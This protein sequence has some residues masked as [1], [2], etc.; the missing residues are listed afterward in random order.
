MQ[1]NAKINGMD[2]SIG[3]EK[4]RIY[5]GIHIKNAAPTMKIGAAPEIIKENI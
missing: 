5:R 3:T 1:I 2:T 4:A